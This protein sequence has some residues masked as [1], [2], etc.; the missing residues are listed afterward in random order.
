[1]GL[2]STPHPPRAL[3]DS[4][5]RRSTGARV[6]APRRGGAREPAPAAG[7]VLGSETDRA[8]TLE[9]IDATETGP[10]RP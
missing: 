9:G 4:E 2:W 1:M 5:A 7:G 8:W 3:R 10:V 6:S